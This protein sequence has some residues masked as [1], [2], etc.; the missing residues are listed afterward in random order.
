MLL[1]RGRAAGHRSV[2][3]RASVHHIRAKP[4]VR[5]TFGALH[6]A[7]DSDRKTKRQ[8]VLFLDYE[9]CQE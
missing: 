2:L 3:G 7:T 6:R 4:N 8:L 5:R 9:T 1:Q